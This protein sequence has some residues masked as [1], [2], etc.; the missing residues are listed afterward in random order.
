VIGLKLMRNSLKWLRKLFWL[1]FF[2]APAAL[3]SETGGAMP[4]E[5]PLQKIAN[6]ISGPVA[7]ALGVI[8]VVITGLAIAFGESGSGVR[9]LLQVLF[10]LA[11][12]F[13]AAS[14]IATLF[15]PSSGVLF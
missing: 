15:H 7:M 2:Y 8:A 14:L 4:W 3:A 9:R 11:I 5:G 12:A 1:G 13:T 10:G 6:S